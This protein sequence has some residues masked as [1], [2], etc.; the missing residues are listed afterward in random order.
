MNEGY[1]FRLIAGVAE[2][3]L[4]RNL[5]FHT[6]QLTFP[7]PS[8]LRVSGEDL[9]ANQIPIPPAFMSLKMI[10]FIC[11]KSF[12]ALE[13]RQYQLFRDNLF[14]VNCRAFVYRD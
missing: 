3:S 6:G 9:A 14:K 2:G 8:L 4:Y 12:N 13:C 1:L 10:K 5:L 7:A 11:S